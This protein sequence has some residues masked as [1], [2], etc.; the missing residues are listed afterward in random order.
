MQ[1]VV[2]KDATAA[3]AKNRRKSIWKRIVSVL[4]CI[5]VFCTTYALILPA[6]T[7]ERTP[8]CGLEEHTHTEACY[9]KHEANAK[10]ALM[11]D[12]ETLALHQHTPACFDMDGRCICG[13]SDFVL[14]SHN[15]F[16]FD[17][18]G[19]LVCTL[20]EISAHIHADDCYIMS[21]P[22]A[23]LS[24]EI[25]GIFDNPVDGS[26]DG[27]IDGS[28]STGLDGIPTDILGHIHT[29]DCYATERGELICT[30]PEEPAHVHTD[31]CYLNT[32]EL[33]CPL[34]EGEGHIHGEGC[35]DEAGALTC[36]LP[37]SAGHT[38]T[39]E[40]Y[41]PSSTL[42]C[43]LGEG[44][45]A[46]VHTDECYAMNE[47]L[48]C[49]IQ[50]E[51]SVAGD[52]SAMPFPESEEWP[53]EISPEN[54]IY[55]VD[56]ETDDRGE[57]VCGI[58]E[59]I[60]H[61][62]DASCFDVS[63]AV[64]CGMPEVLEHIHTQD[65]MGTLDDSDELTCTIAE[66]EGAHF[67]TV[68]AGCFDEEG[69]LVCELE[70]SEGHI[71]G[72]ICYGNWILVCEIEEHTHTDEC[73][74]STE[75]EA[76]SAREAFCGKE[77]H[78]HEG[79]CIDANG[80]V[81]CGVEEHTHTEECYVNP[82][83]EREAFCGKEEHKHAAECVDANGVISC[84]IEEHTHIAECYVDPDAER[85]TFCGKEEHA[86]AAECFDENGM[87]ICFVEEHLHIDT[88]YTEKTAE[89]LL[90]FFPMAA[91]TIV[92]GSAV[93]NVM[94]FEDAPM[95]MSNDVLYAATGNEINF[96]D[97]IDGV[98]LQYNSNGIWVDAPADYTIKKGEKVRFVINYSLD[99]HTLTTE[100][101]TIYYE[102]PAAFVNVVQDGGTVYDGETPIGVYSITTDGERAVVHI[103]F[104]ND[105]VQSNKDGNKIKG[106]VAID[107]YVNESAA[108]DGNVSIKFNESVTVEYKFDDRDQD[109][110]NA[111]P[112]KKISKIDKENGTIQYEIR[113][114]TDHNGT[115][116]PVNVKDEMSGG[117][118][119]DGDISVTLDGTPVNC[120]ITTNGNSF[121]INN[122][123]A[124]E[125]QK[126]YVITYN[127]KLPTGFADSNVDIDTN[128]K[129]TTS[130]EKN[131]T[132]KV[133]KSDD[134]PYKIEQTYL[135]KNGVLNDD[136]IDWT[137]TVNDGTH[138]ISGY[139]LSDILSGVEFTGTVTMNGQEI[140]LPYKFPDGSKDTYVIKYST[141]VNLKPGE[142]SVNN[143]VKLVQDGKPTVEAE[144]TVK[145]IDYPYN[146]VTKT[147]DSLTLNND[148]EAATVHYTVTIN[149][150][151]G[152]IPAPWEFNDNLDDNDNGHQYIN[153]TQKN[154]LFQKIQTACAGRQYSF[155]W[156]PSYDA[157]RVTGF[158]IRFEQPLKKGEIIQFDFDVT[159]ELRGGDKELTFG[160]TGKV[161][162]DNKEFTSWDGIK[163]YPVLRKT[164]ANNESGGSST[165]H[166]YFDD[167][168]NKTG[169]LKWNIYVSPPATYTGGD[170]QLIEQLPAGLTLQKMTVK[171]Q[172]IW[173]DAD[174]T[175]DGVH[176]INGHSEYKFITSIDDI[177]NIIT[178]T[179]PE[180]I[181]KVNTSNKF[182]FYIEAK[183][184]DN[185][186]FNK[187]VNGHPAAE[188][189]NTAKLKMA[190][191]TELGTKTQTQVVTKDETKPPLSKAAG[192][193]KD[194]I[195][196]YTVIVNP[197][198]KDLVEG[199]NKL[200]FTDTA[201]FWLN[202]NQYNDNTMLKFVNSS[203]KVYNLS[204]L[205]DSGN[206]VEI[207]A[208]YLKLKI[209]TKREKYDWGGASISTFTLTLPDETPIKI[210]YNYKV[211]SKSYNS[212]NN[213]ENIATIEG[214]ASSPED[215]KK[216]THVQIVQTAAGASTG[217]LE[218]IKVDS[219][220]YGVTLQ[221][222]KFVLH[223][224]NAETQEYEIAKDK[225]GNNAIYVTDSKGSIKIN[226]I[227][228]NT[229]YYLEEVSP[230]AGYS[231]LGDYWYFMMPNEDKTAYPV[232]K[233]AD[234]K[235]SEYS[236][237]QT[238]YIP[239]ES[240]NT[241]IEVEKRWLDKSG[242]DITSTR[243]DAIQFKLMQRSH[244][245][246]PGSIPTK[247]NIK[248]GVYAWG[249]GYNP[250]FVVSKD[251]DLGSSVTI[252]AIIPNENYDS[253]KLRINNTEVGWTQKIGRVHTYTINNV[254][255]NT[256]IEIDYQDSRYA[257]D[258][259]SYFEKNYTFVITPPAT[260]PRDD[261]E[262]GIYTISEA[263]NWRK[264]I[265][266]LPKT[267]EAPDGAG[268]TKTVYYTYYV[269]EITTGMTD[270]IGTPTYSDTQAGITTGTITITNTVDTAP[271]HELPQTGG[272]GTVPLAI[273]GGGVMAITLILALIK[274]AGYKKRGK[275]DFSSS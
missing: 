192:T 5:V 197:D 224:F 191:N 25:D 176:P 43:T 72:T 267:G 51:P 152:D 91:A 95:M 27:P 98:V 10:Q 77:E 239:N 19:V 40:C 128:N 156:L 112:E 79:E 247:V 86:H 155:T 9:I 258:D 157:A 52:G 47:V 55:N 262:Y 85:E 251:Y 44:E 148:G 49:G 210:V 226:D 14:H 66:G 227:V 64:I 16:C 36:T 94:M 219:E 107:A 194:N 58:P 153:P 222:V 143:K 81:V 131:D 138:D 248:Y 37:E 12:A 181:V 113:V 175:T 42:V 124:M 214:V 68:E 185:A 22:A 24:G 201:K 264:T 74:P 180:S 84:G 121:E 29:D 103:E 45:Q 140:T 137:I 167:N 87:L 31:E 100:K 83:A 231:P 260:I 46:H 4:A 162:F 80:V 129:V 271:K 236:G 38:H 99:A 241:E 67:H 151:L 275:E 245:D 123:P 233:P 150:S 96:R 60:P 145:I 105:F 21:D 273:L 1:N 56:G 230:L 256:F 186:E 26:I 268:G 274:S 114:K 122:L 82:L 71:H 20:P 89:E 202:Q 229:A 13:Y 108:A 215:S 234:F 126:E 17:E 93:D 216:I 161:N 164:D 127:A 182:N 183:I 149:A 110:S 238:I 249:Y 8:E 41:Q 179:I 134:C 146:P 261:T 254:Q 217:G 28:I 193:V 50:D 30:L 172:D 207:N 76:D 63:G 184:N 11:C 147:A 90:G 125:P 54:D 213:L 240:L 78:T 115:T 259:L 266:G 263:D 165:Q 177:N 225:E 75:P 3:V 211:E 206:P 139:L 33:T 188:F 39:P 187:T 232:A 223:K 34:T 101:N 196:P 92:K 142:T 144:D 178:V 111:W 252:T 243:T 136:T 117:L 104:N 35:F 246:D 203:L 73:Y 106:Y 88:C 32:D 154:A 235:G 57:P 118:T 102:L 250:K 18:N 61:C 212:A 169:V 7:L 173:W 70:E 242:K 59:I 97:D 272:G 174:V 130:T 69:N 200:T 208:S 132:S 218:F 160:N 2:I 133:V 158:K 270:L 269:E 204:Q 119:L 244:D 237:G 6:L 171:L 257:N 220:A 209:E 109:W 141:N 65:C 62:H 135:S 23:E 15:E 120:E 265:Q 255:V 163:Y 189:I 53:A 190:D 170:L 159:G 205:D 166:D 198:G 199:T 168:L 195:I 228:Y 221:G 253:P 48:V 116:H